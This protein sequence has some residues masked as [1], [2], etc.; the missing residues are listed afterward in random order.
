L[1][2]KFHAFDNKKFDEKWEELDKD[3][4]NY[5]AKKD[6]IPLMEDLLG[7]DLDLLDPYMQIL[8]DNNADFLSN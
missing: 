1:G 5:I 3:Q 4:N 6:V 8:R 7:I 2:N